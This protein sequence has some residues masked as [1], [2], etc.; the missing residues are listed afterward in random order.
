MSRTC[1]D[2][3]LYVLSTAKGRLMRVGDNN[4]GNL[5]H[6][7]MLYFFNCCSKRT[8]APVTKRI[9]LVIHEEMHVDLHVTCPLAYSCVILTKI[10]TFRVMLLRLRYFRFRENSCCH[11]Q[12]SCYFRTDG[13]IAKFIDV[14]FRHC[15][16]RYVGLSFRPHAATRLLLDGFLIRSDIWLFFE[17]L[18][19]KFCCS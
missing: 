4:Y 16:L 7:C 13:Q 14:L 10:G 3:T 12:S 11:S 18:S 5:A 15:E 1:H 8:L 6:V 17:Y 2:S 9:T 19:R